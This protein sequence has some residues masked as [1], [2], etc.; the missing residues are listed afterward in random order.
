MASPVAA[1]AAQ[2]RL[3]AWVNDPNE[4]YPAEW[5]LVG[6]G[7]SRSKQAAENDA[8]KSIAKVFRSKV[9]VDERLIKSVQESD[10]SRGGL[11]RNSTNLIRNIGISANQT[12]INTRAAEHFYDEKNKKHYVLAVMEKQST[13]DLIKKDIAARASDVTAWRASYASEGDAL[14]RFQHVTKIRQNFAASK[15]LGEMLPILDAFSEGI[16]Y[17]ITEQELD[18]MSA[19]CAKACPI[20]IESSP[21]FPKSTADKIKAELTRFGFQISANKEGSPL[22]LKQVYTKEPSGNAQ[23]VFVHWTLGLSFSYNGNTIAAYEKSGR[24]GQLSQAAAQKRAELKIAKIIASEL[25]TFLGQEL[26]N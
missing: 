3:P 2:D 12:L 13:A 20:Y 24:D 25:P 19:E 18:A 4:K 17:G 26:F 10:G 15:L 21:N 5:N 11:Y 23:M 14:R 16:A 1:F 7:V 22:H 6:L 9:T 8:F